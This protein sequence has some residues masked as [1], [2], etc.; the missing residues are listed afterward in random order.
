MRFKLFIQV[1]GLLASRPGLWVTAF[2]QSFRLAKSGWWKEPPFFPIPANEFIEFRS[3]T[4]Y[5]T[6]EM[7]IE[8]SD[9]LAWLI[10]TKEFDKLK[11]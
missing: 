2:R 9:A 4:Q 8:A 10:W 11:E 3:K 6:L 1:A 7:E 5:G